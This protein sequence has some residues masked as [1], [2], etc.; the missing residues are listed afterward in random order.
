ML[1][2]I[3]F[4]YLMLPKLEFNDLRFMILFNLII[5]R[6]L[7]ILIIGFV[8]ILIF[9]P[10]LANP[11]SVILDARIG[12]P[13]K[14]VTRFILNVSS[15]S[16]FQI[17]S[18]KQPYRLVIDMPD[19]SWALSRKDIP[20]NKGNIKAVRFGKFDNKTSRVVLDL[21]G[22]VKIKKAF[23]KKIENQGGYSAIID[24][25]SSILG[26]FKEESVQ[27]INESVK[28]NN[29]NIIKS[30]VPPKI[31]EKEKFLIEP[32][33]NIESRNIG[34]EK[35]IIPKV[36]TKYK[37]IPMPSPM[38]PLNR[39]NAVIV[40]DPGHGGVDPGATIG[41]RVYEKTITLS[42]ARELAQLLVS[43][44]YLVH[45]TRHDDRYIT[46]A[47]RVNFARSRGAKLFISIHADAHKNKS[48]RGAAIYTLSD[49][50]SDKEAG[51]LAA[52]ENKSYID[53]NIN[54]SDSYDKEITQILI[55]LIQQRTMNCSSKFA[56][57]LIPYLS[58]TSK[59]LDK[60]HR[61]AGF[62]V[63]KAPEVPSVLVELGYLTNKKD[64]KLLLSKDYR[65]KIV[66]QFAA[67]INQYV[68]LTEC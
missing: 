26:G 15:A 28:T 10:C 18:L 1:N 12:Y 68:L 40:L 20:I 8:S 64:R 39:K 36:T 41:N 19:A 9:S 60:T 66:Q 51:R 46:L 11:S 35:E 22:P 37:S 67:A 31:I 34:K 4:Y 48:V 43:E 65:M 49:K 63:L 24:L 45:M 44:G 3:S 62:R 47:D 7:K 17:F 50:A 57:I 58:K 23:I 61:F 5:I 59:L 38:R 6:S 52:R 21:L 29:Q 14:H 30:R 2:I 16:S 56:S 25:E 27:L 55:S 42:F 33:K 32:H 54:I 53:E 13:S